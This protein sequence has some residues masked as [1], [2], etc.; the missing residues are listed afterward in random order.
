MIGRV[1]S[2]ASILTDKYSEEDDSS[3]ERQST[4]RSPSP[5]RRTN[6]PKKAAV[7][8]QQRASALRKKSAGKG[9]DGYE[10]EESEG[11]KML[12]QQYEE[13]P[14]QFVRVGSENFSKLPAIDRAR[15]FLL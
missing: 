13:E 7:P 15:V 1:D 8:K 5:S 3:P 11:T 12:N 4:N 10:S 2:M 9:K 14:Q 6:S